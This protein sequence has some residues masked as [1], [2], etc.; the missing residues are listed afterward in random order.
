MRRWFTIAGTGKGRL[1]IGM[2]ISHDE[3]KREIQLMILRA[4]TVIPQGFLAVKSLE[5]QH[6]Q[7]K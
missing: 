6:S 3:D 7:K 4:E 5:K 2:F 1:L